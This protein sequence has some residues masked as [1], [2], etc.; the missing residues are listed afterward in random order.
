MIGN[1]PSKTDNRRFGIDQSRY[2]GFTDY[3]VLAAAS[4]RVNFCAVQAGISWGY[5]DKLFPHHWIG[6]KSIHVPRAPYH[7]FYPLQSPLEQVKNIVRVVGDDPGEGPPIADIELVHNA[8]RQQLTDNAQEYCELLT[9]KFGRKPIIYTRPSFV[10]DHM[11]R[12]AEWYANYEWWMAIYTTSGLES[13]ESHFLWL[14]NNAG[15]AVPA[16]N[17]LMV[18]TSEKGDGAHFGAKSADLDYD[19]FRGSEADWNRTW[20]IATE[21]PPDPEPE[22]AEPSVITVRYNP[23][24]VRVDLEEVSG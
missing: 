4:S 23:A 7:I 20:S 10:R 9:V 2:Q 22:P 1:L 11:I 8:T 21:P 17:V 19:R 6:L 3:E 16:A 15:I 12:D 5:Q 14:L 18:Q 24:D 13:T